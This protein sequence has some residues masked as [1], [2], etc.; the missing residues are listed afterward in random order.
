MGLIVDLIIIGIIA[1]SVFFG[2]RK[3]L[4]TLG[5]NLCAFI[6]AIVLTLLIYKPVANLVINSSNIDETI[7]NAIY[8]KANE[9]I[10]EQENNQIATE[11]IQNTK[12]EILP[13]TARNIAVNVVTGGVIL[14]LFIAI[15]VALRFV[16]ILANLVAKLPI[17][18]QFNK[19]GGAIYGVLRG[20]LLIYVV[21][22]I[23]GVAGQINPQNTIHKSINEAYIG[24]MMYQNNILNIFFK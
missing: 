12:T 16:N 6:I 14:I 24:K 17:L 1:L 13:E 18:K 19:L 11:L 9:I 5:I 2:Y 7:Q 15:R 10:P 23:I 8:E 22:L 4:V 3:G 21:M 20:L